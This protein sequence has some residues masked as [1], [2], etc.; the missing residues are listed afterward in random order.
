MSETHFNVLFCVDGDRAKPFVG[1]RYDNF[2][3]VLDLF[4]ES[5]LKGCDFVGLLSKVSKD[6]GG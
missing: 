5:S 4:K 3:N 2:V 1:R 6:I